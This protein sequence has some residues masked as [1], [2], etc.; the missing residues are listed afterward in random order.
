MTQVYLH[1]KLTLIAQ[2][3][4][5][6]KIE[7]NSKIKKTENTELNNKKYKKLNKNKTNTMINILVKST[8]I[9]HIN[10]QNKLNVS[11]KKTK[12]EKK[13]S[14]EKSTHTTIRIIIKMKI[15]IV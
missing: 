11:T 7:N 12:K 5:N 14:K 3:P 2:K 9:I 4:K 6:L 10:I 8:K 15:I 13:V 1:N